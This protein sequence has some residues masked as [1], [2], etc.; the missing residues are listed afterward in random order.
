M[1]KAF[2]PPPPP[3]P[4]PF[5]L[6]LPLS[7]PPL[8]PSHH[9]HQVV[10]STVTPGLEVELYPVQFVLYKHTLFPPQSPRS[11][12]QTVQVVWNALCTALGIREGGKSQ[13][14]QPVEGVAQPTPPSRVMY[15]RAAF[16]RNTTIEEVSACTYIHT[17]VHVWVCMCVHTPVYKWSLGGCVDSDCGQVW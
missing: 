17:Y 7:P 1:V 4:F 6:S 5:P 14:S 11:S 16:G 13:S 12:Y 15:Y 3:S 10:A 9:M 2:P 8:L